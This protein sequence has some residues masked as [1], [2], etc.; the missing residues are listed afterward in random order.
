[1]LPS[2]LEEELTLETGFQDAGGSE[3]GYGE[4]PEVAPSFTPKILLPPLAQ[5]RDFGT[6]FHTLPVSLRHCD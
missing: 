2:E 3:G 6:H 4:V 1:M 5:P